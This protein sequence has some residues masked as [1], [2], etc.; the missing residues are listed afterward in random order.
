M[1][2]IGNGAGPAA[3]GT[4]LIK[5]SNAESFAADVIDASKD[6]LVLVD[7][8]A[9]WCG[10]CKQL[11]PLLE[12]IVQQKNGAVRLVKI[13]IDENQMIAQEMRIQ[14]IPAVFAFKDGQPVDGFMGA[15][16][17]SQITAFID[18]HAG[19]AGPGPIDELLASGEAALE[20]GDAD[21]AAQIFARVLQ[22]E[23]ANLAAISGLARSYL[24]LKDITR[25][26]E[27]LNL[28]PDDKTG[29][30]VI[31]SVTAALAL[32]EQAEEAGDASALQ[33]EVDAAP[34][35]HEKRMEYANALLARDDKQGAVEQL[36][37]SIRRDKMWNDQAARK[38]LLTLFEAFGPEDPITID[39][40]ARLS[41][42]LFS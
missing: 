3:G 16:P 31:E 22:E 14:S 2:L 15:L 39:G 25:A 34:D 38:Q 19:P 42:I 36:L 32:A 5:D 6:A 17:E 20:Q 26:R 27:I 28:V 9:P 18:K 11:G 40:R 8:W 30:P 37:E 4:D 23:A 7:F 13:N 41:I 29:D 21:G 24:A 1:A 10:P 33:A 12:K 35:N